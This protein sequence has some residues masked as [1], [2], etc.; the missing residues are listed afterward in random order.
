MAHDVNVVV[1]LRVLSNILVDVQLS[2][3]QY[4]SGFLSTFSTVLPF[5]YKPISSW[6]MRNLTVD[7][8]LSLFFFISFYSHLKNLIPVES[9]I[10]QK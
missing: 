9:V 8:H 3:V 4:R 5:G 10:Q 2:T 7:L 1:F 6:R